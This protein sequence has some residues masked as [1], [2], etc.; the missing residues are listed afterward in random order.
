MGRLS[1]V[2]GCVMA[3]RGGSAREWAGA[4][5][6]LLLGIILKAPAWA[7]FLLIL[8]AG[9]IAT[10]EYCGI[11]YGTQQRP[12][13]ALASLCSGA[14]I[15]TMYLWPQH[16]LW[17]ITGTG[18][19]LFLL[20]L[21]AYKDQTQAAI[22]LN[23]SAFGVLYGGVMLGCLALMRQVGA[24]AG[25]YWVI[26]ALAIIWGS[27]TGAYFA[28][29]AFGKRK[30]APRITLH[31][32]FM[33]IYSIGV[34][35]TGESG[36]GKSEL[37]LELLSRGHRLVA[38]D[39]PEFTQIAPDVLDGTCPELLQDLLELRGLGVLNIREMFGDTAVK[40]NK[41]LRL[42]VHLA[43]PEDSRETQDASGMVR[44]T[45]DLGSRR[46]LDLDVPMITLPVMPGRNLAVLTEAATRVHMLR[47]K[48]VD[49]AA[50]FLARHSQFLERGMQ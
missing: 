36:S 37:A 17:G 22:Q 42:V 34:L 48:G 5:V 9:A 27:D 25:P 26:I 31:G 46:V 50:A 6:P 44:L 29:R 12:A 21:F 40:R 24:D 35:I 3:A 43:R 23:A 11:C 10:W 28:G 7:F 49:P 18:I 32:V 39:A 16:L 33:E 19:A 13:Q 41:Y 2:T 30:L 4:A 20:M 15:A 38:D 1:G 8:V 45:G 14:L 47:A